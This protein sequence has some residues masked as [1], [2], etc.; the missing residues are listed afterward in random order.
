MAKWDWD[1]AFLHHIQ[2]NGLIEPD[3]DKEPALPLIP[4]QDGGYTAET[5]VK[6]ETQIRSSVIGVSFYS[7]WHLQK[8]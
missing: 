7:A 8:Q 2:D 5:A 1:N 3:L 6:L 4:T